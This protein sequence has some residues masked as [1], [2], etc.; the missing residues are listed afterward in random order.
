MK[1]KRNYAFSPQAGIL[2]AGLVAGSYA[3]ACYTTPPTQA[4]CFLSGQNV[5]EITW[6]SGAQFVIATANWDHGFQNGH[7]VLLSSVVASTSSSQNI[8]SLSVSYC[9]GPAKYKDGAGNMETVTYWENGVANKN[10]MHNSN[11]A[12]PSTPINGGTYTW[13][14][15]QLGG[16]C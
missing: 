12:T 16:T 10:A 5:D 15:G 8:N 2:I 3:Q 9:Y 1:K 7:A 13:S 14:W 11:Y 4:F 6:N